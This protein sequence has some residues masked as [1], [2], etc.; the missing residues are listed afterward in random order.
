MNI[1]YDPENGTPYGDAHCEDILKNSAK[2]G[3]DIV[4]ST[5]NI[6]NMA[7]AL[8]HEEVLDHRDVVFLFKDHYIRVDKFGEISDYPPGFCEF[9]LNTLLRLFDQKDK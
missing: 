3:I 9:T 2:T 5:E 6:I 1:T 8:V 7:R 4:T